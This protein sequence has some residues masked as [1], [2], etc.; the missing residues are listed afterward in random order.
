MRILNFIILIAL[1][2]TGCLE[3]KEPIDTLRLG[4]TV[5]PGY[6][7][8]YLGQEKEIID[9]K[10][11]HL[12]Q[13][14]SSSQT[15][16]A[17]RNGQIDAA[18]LTLYDALLLLNEGINVKV[19][20]VL[21]ISNGGDVIISQKGL[22][23][24]EALKGKTVGLEN[25]TMGLHVLSRAL[26]INNMR[27]EDIKI[28]KYEG[29]EHEKAFEERSVDAIVTYEP[30]RSVMLNSGAHELFSS[31]QM[32]DEIID[33]LIVREEY[34]SKHPKQIKNLIT[35][36]YKTL[37]FY[38]DYP[39]ESDKFF[40]KR[41]KLNQKDVKETFETIILPTI[42]ENFDFLN[43]ENAQLL[44][45]SEDIEQLMLN[46]KQV[47]DKADVGALLDYDLSLIYDIK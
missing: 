43:T 26:T 46:N 23:K 44:K 20:L 37:K 24:F 4:S 33:V 47:E 21:D 10:N 31:K 14:I 17:F 1:L 15:L 34:L 22:T 2:F 19:I 41:L 25:S 29:Y 45:I 9:N 16:R 40:A 30:M 35:N 27:I 12:V 3:K 6:E 38:E 36:W 5:W 13:Y 28:K 42:S 18:A 7:P 8:L 39:I 11:I 32:P